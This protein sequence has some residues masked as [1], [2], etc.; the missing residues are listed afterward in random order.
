MD[1][2]Q[3]GSDT[4]MAMVQMW[5]H[6][7]KR[8]SSAKLVGH[9]QTVFPHPMAAERVHEVPTEQKV[10]STHS[11]DHPGMVGQTAGP[12]LELRGGPVSGVQ[13]YG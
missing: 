9:S 10:R 1:G 7:S 4:S 6:Q 5:Y 3:Q 2:T 11:Q 12:S 13:T 8:I